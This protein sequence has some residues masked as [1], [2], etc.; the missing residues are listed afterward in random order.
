MITGSDVFHY[1][2]HM[3][4]DMTKPTKWVCTQRRLRSA[5]VWL[6]SAR[7]NLVSLATYWAHS[8]T[9]I[10]LGGCPG[11]SESS[12][13]WYSFCL[14]C[15]AVTHIFCNWWRSFYSCKICYSE[16]IIH[17]SHVT[18]GC[19]YMYDNLLPNVLMLWL[20]NFH[21]SVK[22]DCPVKFFSRVSAN[23][24]LLLSLRILRKYSA[25]NPRWISEIDP[26]TSLRDSGTRLER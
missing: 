13:G 3:T 25:L 10:S 7:R 9:L 16:V 17:Y 24:Y 11:W 15:H 4:H 21:W 12:L 1:Q 20:E 5:S 18:R 6:E 14:F 19:N 8:E 2:W 26:I 22:S 23:L